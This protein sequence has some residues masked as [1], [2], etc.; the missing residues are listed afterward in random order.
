[1]PIVAMIVR[2]VPVIPA[3]VTAVPGVVDLVEELYDWEYR[4]WIER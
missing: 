4:A 1:M 3:V 2:T